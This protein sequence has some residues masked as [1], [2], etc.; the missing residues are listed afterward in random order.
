M[1]DDSLLPEKSKH[2]VAKLKDRCGLI[3]RIKLHSFTPYLDF[4]LRQK[5]RAQL[6][7]ENMDFPSGFEKR[8]FVYVGHK[9][10]RRIIVLNYEEE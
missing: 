4:A 10:F 8:R 3:K 7:T 6:I 5:L 1:I 9:T 2:L